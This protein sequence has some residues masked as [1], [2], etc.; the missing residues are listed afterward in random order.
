M[1]SRIGGTRVALT[2]SPMSWSAPNANSAVQELRIQL[3]RLCFRQNENFD[4]EIQ[5]KILELAEQ[6]RIADEKKR[7]GEASW[8]IFLFPPLWIILPFALIG[9]LLESRERTK[10]D[11]LR[12]ER[13]AEAVRLAHSRERELI[14]EKI[15]RASTAA[16]SVQQANRGPRGGANPP[17]PQ[18]GGAQ[19][20]KRGSRASGSAR[21]RRSSAGTG[22]GLG[23]SLNKPVG[24][25]NQFTPTI[26][27][28]VRLQVAE[29]DSWICQLCLKPID[30]TD[31]DYDFSSP[32]PD[33]LEVDH[34]GPVNH[35]GGNE[36]SNL[37]AAH[38]RCNQ[39][40]GGRYISN[41]EYRDWMRQTEESERRQGS[42]SYPSSGTGPHSHHKGAGSRERPA[43][44]MLR[45]RGKA[46]NQEQQRRSDKFWSTP[47]VNAL[48][49]ECERGHPYSEDNTYYFHSA[50]GIQRQCR[51]CRREAKKRAK[52]S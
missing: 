39:R 47:H 44:G 48:W 26:P 23:K 14:E 10:R 11:R 3:E 1:S 41:T 25:D 31:L 33:R 38:R 13:A 52:G 50:D 28:A 18:S 34:I 12:P 51:T 8:W 16:T 20:L 21:G 22:G 32:N 9:L 5:K 35:G 45:P 4:H 37:Q 49:F 30:H 46:I 42:T 36:T 7:E 6:D 15:R 43:L 2:S 19:H 17:A 27:A 24:L 29:R 40:K